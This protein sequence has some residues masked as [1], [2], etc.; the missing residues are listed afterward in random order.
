MQLTIVSVDYAPEELYGQTPLVIDLLR[1]IPGPDRPDYWLGRAV[2]PIIW[3]DENIERQITHVIVAA[4]WEGTRIEPHVQNLPIGIA[5]VTDRD[6]I[7]DSLVSFDKCKYIAI[8]FSHETQGGE[9]LSESKN[10]LAGTITRSFGLGN[11][12]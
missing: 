4:R 5:Y 8:G 2:K 6:Q 1:E 7:N 10:I 12:T 3:L 11:K 9:A